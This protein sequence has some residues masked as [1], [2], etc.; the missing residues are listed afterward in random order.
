V[1]KLPEAL[2]Q[3]I[4][5]A[6][7]KQVEQRYQ[8]ARELGDELKRLKEE[9]EFT[10]RL[11]GESGSKD[12]ILTLTVG[13]AVDAAEHLT[14]DTRL[15][16]KPLSF[17]MPPGGA[18]FAVLRGWLRQYGKVLV[19]AALALVISAG[20]LSWRRLAPQ[21]GA[22][23]SVAVLPFANI[24]A[25]PQMAYMPDGLTESLIDSLSQLPALRVS[26]HSTVSGYKGRE[27][28]P[29]Q[30][31]KELQ[32]RVVV[33]GRVV[34]QG[35]RL[36]IRVELVDAANG[37][38]V[39]GDEFQRTRSDI[40][41][42][43]GEIA[44]EISAKLH[45]RL[46]PSSQQQLAKRHSND[47]KA[48]ELYAQ[49]RYLY[50][51]Y[52]RQSQEKALDHFRQAIALDSRYALAHCGV[53]DVYA[54]FSSQYLPPSEAMP[55]ARAAALKA[56]EIDETLPDAHHSLALVK[57]WGDWDWAG[58]ERE[59]QRA[60]ELN[61]NFVHAR[62]YY[63]QFLLQQKRFEEAL[64]VIEQAKAYDPASLLALSREG[65]VYALMRRYDRAIEI[66]RKVLGL[67]PNLAGVQ[68]NLSVAL[69]Q[70]GRHQEAIAQAN[71]FQTPALSATKAYIYARAGRRGEAM[72]LLRE[73]KTLA[74]H[75]PVSPVSIARIYIG[76]GDKEQALVWL[77]KAY[78]ERSDHL[79]HVGADP[80]FDPLRSD[81][82]F[83][84][85]LRGI[86][87]TR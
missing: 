77:G 50:L 5:R 6:L 27:V 71:Q 26:A 80:A 82:R 49:G 68:R 69:S 40:V 25:D 35:D 36:I 33:T 38:R 14:F 47:S 66:Y 45:R 1:T 85:L 21:D 67:N 2:Q 43:Q 48:Y 59:Y 24:G 51:Q 57:W 55:K 52:D 28:D 29:R 16:V 70:Q 39:W 74:A 62:I 19:V 15:A 56:I 17:A 37:S 65:D 61:P 44:R 30:A 8:T 64:R 60:L 41:T 78:E 72:K 76:L 86:G 22:I 81:P 83:D 42:T 18:R 46:S 53:A 10:A 79:L 34:R 75:E 4:N 20:V 63:A 54:D 9:L 13:V 7:A 11:K 31:G 87:L 84:E 3:I 23:D 32:V 12:D 58:A 73:L